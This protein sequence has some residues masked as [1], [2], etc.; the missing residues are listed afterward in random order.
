MRRRGL[1]GLGLRGEGVVGLVVGLVLG[2]GSGMGLGFS[3]GLVLERMGEGEG[4]LEKK[5]VI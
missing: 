2:L 1:C 4:V 3:L 5:E